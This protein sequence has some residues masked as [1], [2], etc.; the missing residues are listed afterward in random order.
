[1]K[2]WS[3]DLSRRP[4]IR[5]PVTQIEKFECGT[6]GP[7]LHPS[8]IARQ[9][10]SLPSIHDRQ[11][12]SSQFNQT[13]ESFTDRVYSRMSTEHNDDD[14]HAFESILNW[15]QLP[16]PISKAEQKKFQ[17]MY[18]LDIS[19]GNTT[20]G[21]QYPLLADEIDMIDD[22][23]AC[24]IVNKWAFADLVSAE[25]EKFIEV[26]IDNVTKSKKRTNP[27]KNFKICIRKRPLT[28]F[29]QT[30]FKE[31]DIISIVDPQTTLLHIPS[32][33]IDNQ[34]F[35]K[36][37]KFK[38]NQTFDENCQISTIYHST[39]APLLDKAIDGSK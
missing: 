18:L 29:E 31:V 17:Y 22:P 5:L 37:R 14:E 39:L 20:R 27:N 2:K 6:I 35:I 15:Q 33:T 7:R 16:H 10:F 23:N 24:T 25:R 30:I 26:P 32:I 13:T 21:R 8:S 36:N 3:H 38:C 9:L 28:E 34:V 19:S 11:H 4:V 1:M 12:L